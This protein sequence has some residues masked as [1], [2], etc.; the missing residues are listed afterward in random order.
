MDGL[1]NRL[2]TPESLTRKIRDKAKD[3]GIPEEEYAAK[4]GDALRYTMVLPDNSFSDGAQAIMDTI[5]KQ[6][7]IKDVENSFVPD[8]TYKGLH[9]TLVDGETGLAAELQL[10]TESSIAAKGPSHK[11]FEKIRDPATPPEENLRL[12]E[13]LVSLWMDVPDP[14]R[15]GMFGKK[16]VRKDLTLA[17][18]DHPSD[19]Q[20]RSVHAG[21]YVLQ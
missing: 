8:N 10:H 15:A 6:Y 14:P 1:K 11:L 7:T 4:I 12:R 21:L 2:K 5:G 17:P 9:M 20:E 19:L 16:V 3:K 18:S 13:Q